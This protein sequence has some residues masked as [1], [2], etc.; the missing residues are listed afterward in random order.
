MPHKA[1]IDL[2][3]YDPK[4]DAYVLGVVETGDGSAGCLGRLQERL[5]DYVDIAVD[6]HLA[7]QYPESRGKS[8]VIRLDCYDSPR[9]ACEQFFSR[10]AEHIHSSGEIQAAIRKHGH[11]KDIDFE[12]SWRTLTGAA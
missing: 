6:G 7:Q 2:V 1:T 9:E 8:V 4:R 5:Y 3:T 12:F 11:I 10:F